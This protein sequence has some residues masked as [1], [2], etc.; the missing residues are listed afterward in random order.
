AHDQRIIGA[1]GADPEYMG[2]LVHGGH[3]VHG[4]ATAEANGSV[5]ISVGSRHARDVLGAEL[6]LY[7]RVAVVDREGIVERARNPLIRVLLVVGR[8]FG[9]REGV[10]DLPLEGT[11]PAASCSGSAGGAPACTLSATACGAASRTAARRAP[12]GDSWCPA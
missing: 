5:R 9:A 1:V 8:I 4:S 2:D 12:A 7:L 6:F 10:G 11:F 3:E